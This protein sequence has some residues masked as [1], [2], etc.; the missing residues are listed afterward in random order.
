MPNIDEHVIHFQCPSCGHEL[1]QTI[2]LL[3]AEQRLVCAGCGVGINFDTARVVAATEALEA[4]LPSAP[5]EITIK[6]FRAKS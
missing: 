4:A 5:N 2:G 6:F 3:K 1:H